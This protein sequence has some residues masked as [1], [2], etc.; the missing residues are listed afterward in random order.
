MSTFLAFIAIL[1]KFFGHTELVRQ[2]NHWVGHKKRSKNTTSVTNQWFLCCTDSVQ[3]TSSKEMSKNYKKG[4]MVETKK[5]I[6]ELS[7]LITFLWNH[8]KD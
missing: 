1:L 4:D 6:E 7:V 2:R 5:N 3:Q 8:I